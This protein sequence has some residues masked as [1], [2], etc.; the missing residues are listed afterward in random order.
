MIISSCSRALTGVW[1]ETPRQ[2]NGWP[3]PGRRALTGVWIETLQTG[4]HVM[5]VKRRA[6]TGVWIETSTW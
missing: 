5:E 3:V 2:Y 1:I 4:A 6:L